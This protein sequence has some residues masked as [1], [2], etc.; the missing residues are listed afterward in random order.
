[1]DNRVS[2]L[3]V[4]VL[5]LLSGLV[6]MSN[7]TDADLIE[8]TE[9]GYIDEDVR[10][11]GVPF[12][13]GMEVSTF[14][15]CFQ[16]PT[17]W[18]NNTEPNIGEVEL[19]Y[20]YD[21]DGFF[22]VSWTNTSNE[23]DEETNLYTT[24]DPLYNYYVR[25]AS[26]AVNCEYKYS[27]VGLGNNTMFLYNDTRLVAVYGSDTHDDYDTC[28]ST[29]IYIGDNTLAVIL[30]NKRQ[31]HGF[32]VYSI[33]ISLFN[34]LTETPG[35]INNII[36]D[37]WEW[38]TDDY[39]RCISCEYQYD[40]LF[41]YVLDYER[42]YVFTLDPTV[43]S[44]RAPSHTVLWEGD[45]VPRDAMCSALRP[46]G[47][48]EFECLTFI[49][50]EDGTRNLSRIK[51]NDI[52]EVN[53][54]DP[55]VKDYFRWGYIGDSDDD[56]I[57]FQFG[58]S[59]GRFFVEC[60]WDF[61]AHSVY[62]IDS[63]DDTVYSR[64]SSNPTLL[65]D[66]IITNPRDGITPSVYNRVELGDE[67]E[68]GEIFYYPERVSVGDEN[69]DWYSDMVSVGQSENYTYPDESGVY[70]GLGYTDE[71]NYV[72]FSIV[73]ATALNTNRVSEVTLVQEQVIEGMIQPIDDVLGYSNSTVG[74]LGGEMVYITS[75]AAE[76]TRAMRPKHEVT[77]READGTPIT[78][79]TLLYTD[80][81]RPFYVA[82]VN[83]TVYIMEAHYVDETRA[84]TTRTYTLTAHIWDGTEWE[85]DITISEYT[86]SGMFSGTIHNVY[87]KDGLLYIVNSTDYR[88]DEPVDVWTMTYN[89][90]N[91]SL[92]KVGN[93]TLPRDYRVV[94]TRGNHS[95]MALQPDMG[96]GSIY[97]DE[98]EIEDGWIVS[99]GVVGIN[100]NGSY[101]IWYVKDVG[102]GYL[103][104][105]AGDYENK[106]GFSLMKTPAGL[107]YSPPEIL[108]EPQ[109]YGEGELMGVAMISSPSLIW[110]DEHPTSIPEMKGSAIG[111]IH[112]SDSDI[113]YVLTYDTVV[114]RGTRA[115]VSEYTEVVSYLYMIDLGGWRV[116]DEGYTLNLREG[117][118]LVSV[119]IEGLTSDDIFEQCEGDV[120][121][122]SMRHANGNYVMEI[123]Y[124]T[125]RTIYNIAP[126]DGFYLFADRD[127]SVKI[128]GE[129]VSNVSYNLSYGWNLIGAPYDY[130]VNV[131]DFKEDFDLE[132]LYATVSRIETGEYVWY[133]EDFTSGSPYDVETGN[134]Y[135]VYL[136]EDTGEFY[137]NTTA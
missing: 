73:N 87:G 20:Q 3:F 127:F 110:L 115:H 58:S 22:Y 124:N 72:F 53:V 123:Y 79:T 46:L 36:T 62:Y 71:C 48:D 47:E 10:D 45:Y 33:E 11:K 94:S 54:F 56:S 43:L 52:E 26:T 77:I 28:H 32:M 34:M 50:G 122:F 16:A 27:L 128:L 101:F 93:F 85:M 68:L 130:D 95:V 51:D 109:M 61:K 119:P 21:D 63:E 19:L 76:I 66:Y 12:P 135:L 86:Y 38:N 137:I 55:I 104:Y 18:V 131:E 13:L 70:F 69:T 80:W 5:F 24:E 84:P 8:M 9:N 82:F 108:E 37:T 97:I 49:T 25:Y 15:G 42:H 118:N 133:V 75:S 30:S 1:M 40:L 117:W 2:T 96:S 129:V 14:S 6:L 102:S 81:L 98:M 7:Q 111:G 64:S 83:E 99:E 126:S 88:D 112:V 107:K 92:L 125:N 134:G 59:N 90:D 35:T 105:K 23:E 57:L 106:T 136:Y 103:Y 44:T 116:D 121:A 17:A 120:T 89:H 100:D 78:S 41:F 113:A 67:I 60:D 91:G 39:H 132:H 114:R 4:V 65:D 29:A 74:E 31:N